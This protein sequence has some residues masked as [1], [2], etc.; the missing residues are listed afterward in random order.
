MSTTFTLE[1]D[2]SIVAGAEQEARRR[3]TTVAEVL[4]RQLQVMA[5]NW[6]LS[7]TGKTP[8]T[9]SLRGVI[10]VPADFDERGALVSE[11]LKRDGP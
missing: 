3:Q 7:Q 1:L 5:L 8:V 6:Q 10:H 4:A 9:D 11:L 2:P